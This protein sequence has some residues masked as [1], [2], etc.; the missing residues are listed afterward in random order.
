VKR[1][2][3]LVKK[4]ESGALTGRCYQTRAVYVVRWATPTPIHTK[5]M[6]LCTNH[7]GVLERK[8]DIEVAAGVRRVAAA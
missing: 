8:G 5:T 1:C 4:R 6:L 3:A 7:R 2:Q